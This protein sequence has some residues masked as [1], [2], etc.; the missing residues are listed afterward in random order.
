MKLKQSLGQRQRDGEGF[1]NG[2]GQETVIGNGKGSGGQVEKETGVVL[3][4]GKDVEGEDDK[5]EEECKDC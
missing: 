2:N 1:G 3:A 5:H 4:K